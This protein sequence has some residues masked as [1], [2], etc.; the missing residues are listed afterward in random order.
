MSFAF[1]SVKSTEKYGA[2]VSYRNGRMP[3]KT[4]IPVTAKGKCL[5][6][7]DVAGGIKVREL[8]EKCTDAKKKQQQQPR[9]AGPGT[10]PRLTRQCEKPERTCGRGGKSSAA[11]PPRSGPRL[12]HRC[13]SQSNDA[14]E[15]L[16]DAAAGGT[17]RGGPS[18][19]GVIH[20]DETDVTR[21]ER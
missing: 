2:K 5:A 12:P 16:P 4:N 11:V 19:R 8:D 7:A 9:V 17:A 18:T 6:E 14:L 15:I 3:R 1:L 13:A 20:N 21:T 10:K